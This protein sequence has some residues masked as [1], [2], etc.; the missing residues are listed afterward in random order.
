VGD[1]NYGIDKLKQAA[2]I[3]Q[4]NADIYINIGLCYRKLGGEQGGQA[5]E[6]FRQAS[7]IDPQNPRPYYYIGRIY[8]SQRNKES[9]NEWYNKAI[10]A[11]ATFAPVYLQYFQYYSETDVSAAKE[12]LDK[13]VAN[14]DKDCTT[15]YFVGD[16]LFAAGKYQESLQKAKEDG[17]RRHVKI[18]PGLM[19]CMP[20]T[21]TGW[22]IQSRRRSYLQKYLQQPARKLYNLQIML[23]E[24]LF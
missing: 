6:A 24:V 20:M 12:Y 18:S 21:M 13:Y 3:D 5:F 22:E 9:M 14:A 4:K 8:Q 2:Q 1:P 10:A 17:S 19:S 15:D 7:A 16:Y 23:L 11:D